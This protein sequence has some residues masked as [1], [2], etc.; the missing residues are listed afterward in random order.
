MDFRTDDKASVH[1]H[2]KVSER[3]VCTS[4]LGKL[5]LRSYFFALEGYRSQSLRKRWNLWM[6]T[7]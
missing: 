1:M 2:V 5:L 4:F 3:G 6:T 7:L